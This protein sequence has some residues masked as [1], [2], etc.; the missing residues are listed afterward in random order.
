[1]RRTTPGFHVHFC[2]AS[3]PRKPQLEANGSESARKKSG[4]NRPKSQE[5][6]QSGHWS[7]SWCSSVGWRSLRA[8][9]V[10]RARPWVH[11]PPCLLL[12]LL[13]VVTLRQRLARLRLHRRLVHRRRSRS[14]RC[15]R[16]AR[17]HQ[18]VLHRLPVGRARGHADAR[19]VDAL[20]RHQVVLGV[21]RALRRELVHRGVLVMLGVLLLPW[22]SWPPRPPSARPPRLPWRQPA[23]SGPEPPG[24]GKPWLRCR[25][26]WAASCRS[27][28]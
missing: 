15:E 3:R 14:R 7:A 9:P 25:R 12:G 1:M 5:A 20:L 6:N 28:S 17:G 10:L 11:Q 18:V 4:R 21:H 16:R 19:S 27:R 26:A 2:T 22:P 24:P 23:A 13:C 8:L